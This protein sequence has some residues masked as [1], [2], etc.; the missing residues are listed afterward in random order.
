MKNMK[1]MYKGKLVR[2]AIAEA[3]K[4]KSYRKHYEAAKLRIRLAEEVFNARKNRGLSQQEL[5]KMIG[6]TQK[7][8]SNIENADVNIGIDLLNR[9]A[10]SLN[11]K[12]ENFGVIFNCSSV[13]SAPWIYS[14]EKEV[15]SIDNC[16]VVYK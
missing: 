5:A 11:F 12:S 6:T 9:I 1:S 4:D 10:K 8:L 13:I 3:K 7:V 14:T 16:K 2:D 15:Y